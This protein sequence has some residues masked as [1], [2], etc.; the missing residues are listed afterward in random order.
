MGTAHDKL[1]R[2]LV[3]VQ[4]DGDRR[5]GMLREVHIAYC[6][7]DERWRKKLE[8]HFRHF[9]IG[10]ARLPEEHFKSLGRFPIGKPGSPQIQ[11]FEFKAFQV[12]LYGTIVNVS[13]AQTFVGTKLIDD[14][15]RNRAD[16][17]LL[18]RIATDFSDYLDPR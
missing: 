17:E 12:R 7:L 8:N 2:E 16:Q 18:K 14:K 6:G 3:M 5:V 15:K 1:V 9:G 10:N 11:L 13:D 4:N